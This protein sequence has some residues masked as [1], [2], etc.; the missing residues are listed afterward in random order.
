MRRQACIDTQRLVPDRSA[1]IP[2]PCPVFPVPI[3][4]CLRSAVAPRTTT[5][6]GVIPHGWSHR[7]SRALPAPGGEPVAAAVLDEQSPLRNDSGMADSIQATTLS[8][9]SASVAQSD[10]E[11][12]CIISHPAVPGLRDPSSGYL[13]GRT[14]HFRGLRRRWLWRLFWHY[15]RENSQRRPRRLV[16]GALAVPCL[17]VP[18]IADPRLATIGPGVPKRLALTPD[19]SVPSVSG[20]TF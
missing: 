14:E 17:A 9:T 10:S 11:G 20:F 3:S 16:P 2:A 8:D 12:N 19:R 1:G 6:L 13:L 4:A 18:A 5:H 15:Q 7:A